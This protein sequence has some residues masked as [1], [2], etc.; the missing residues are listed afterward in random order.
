MGQPRKA[1]G[2]F[3]ARESESRTQR[4]DGL[5]YERDQTIMKRASAMKVLM[6]LLLLGGVSSIQPAVGAGVD[7]MTFR[8]QDRGGGREARQPR[9]VRHAQ[10]SPQPQPPRERARGQMSEEE[11]RQLHRDLDKANREIYRG[12]RP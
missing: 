12:K 9:E 1:G 5:F 11:R 3:Q 10:P 6:A 7:G 2:V 4:T 8:V